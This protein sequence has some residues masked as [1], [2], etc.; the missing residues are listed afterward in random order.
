MS[1]ELRHEPHVHHAVSFVEHHGVDF[2]RAQ[3]AAEV[4][5]HESARC[6]NDDFGSGFKKKKKKARHLG[7]GATPPTKAVERMSVCM[8]NA[9]AAR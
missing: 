8:A 9:S 4:K 2:P 3:C 5:L 7:F 6:G 1:S